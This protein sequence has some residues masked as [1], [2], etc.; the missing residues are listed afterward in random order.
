ME[1][2]K[3][4]LEKLFDDMLRQINQ[5]K[6]KTYSDA[7]LKG[8]D[9]H[10]E[11]FENI[12][13]ECSRRESAEQEILLDELSAVIPDYAQDKMEKFSKRNKEKYSLNFNLAM[14]VYIVPM[15][16]YT[17]DPFCNQIAEKMVAR[18]NEN[19]VTNMKIRKSDFER[20][21]GGFK[22]KW[23]YITTAVCE[24]QNKPDNCHELSTL[25]AYRDCYLNQTEEGRNLIEEYYNIAP[26]IVMAL[27]LRPDTGE[28]Y[29]RIYQDYLR[30]CVSLADS[31]QYQECKAL[32]IDM[33]RHLEKEY[34]YLS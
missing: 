11:V 4:N 13:G 33:V 23:C 5:F 16:V 14:V 8:Y 28:I 30:H 25:R 34:L 29:D 2:T 22:K 6:R 27:E 31:G 15:F 12:I 21:D 1:K 19:K 9:S 7:F 10:K 24:K 20:I 32:Y 17:K 18:W 26:A 3:D